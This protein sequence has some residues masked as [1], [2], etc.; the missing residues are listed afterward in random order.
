MAK[1]FSPVNN[2]GSRTSQSP[3]SEDYRKSFNSD[4]IF[5][6][7]VRVVS[8]DKLIGSSRSVR[9]TADDD[10]FKISGKDNAGLQMFRMSTF[11]ESAFGKCDSDRA[12]PRR[13]QTKNSLGSHSKLLGD[14]LLIRKWLKGR[15]LLH[16]LI[17]Y[18][19]E[20]CTHPARIEN[21]SSEYNMMK[22]LEG[23]VETEKSKELDGKT[24]C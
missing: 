22:K 14:L 2:N 6:T 12:V 21:V 20:V 3:K 16:E 13:S 18:G 11:G 9:D 24:L 5:K 19:E 17:K 4:N 10:P 1:V 23:Y 7:L 8:E 15:D